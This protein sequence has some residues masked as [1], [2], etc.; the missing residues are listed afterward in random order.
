M[1]ALLAC[2]GGVDAPDDHGHDAA[3]WGSPAEAE[4]LDPADDVVH[5]ELTAAPRSFEVGGLAIDGYAYNDQNP[6]PTLRAKAGDTL[7]VDFTNALDADTTVHWHGVHAPNDMDGVG[8]LVPPGGTFTYTLPLETAGTFWYHPHVDVDR[9]VDLGLYGFLVVEDPGEP[10]MDELLVAFDTW[11]EL[12]EE[13]GD[14]A[15]D[16]HDHGMGDHGTPVDPDTLTWTANGVVLPSASFDGPVRARLL[17]ASNTSY[18]DLSGVGLRIAGEQGLLDTSDTSGHVLL[19]PGDRAELEWTRTVSLEASPYS[20]AG[21]ATLGEPVKVL[22]VEAAGSPADWPFAGEPPADDP[23]RTDLVYVFSGGDHGEAWLINGEAWPDVTP[24]VL[25]LGTDAVIEVRN[26][27]ATEHPFHVH[28]HAF[29]VLSVDGVPVAS[30][31]VEDTV[32]V[33]I[34]QRVRLRMLADNPGEWMVHCHI[35]GHEEG[36]MMT[37]LRVE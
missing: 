26:L 14:A 27:S 17:N 31:Q 4:D 24:S 23:G 15:K 3:A 10:V 32:N 33:G 29:E 28:G 25:A 16:E 22:R 12:D 30:R 1:I 2:G 7:I 20:V 19:G 18:L 6:G 9:Q 8:V 37:V 34:R 13:E 5:V 35:L 36:G 21:G 11:S